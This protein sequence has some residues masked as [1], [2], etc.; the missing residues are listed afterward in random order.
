MKVVAILLLGTLLLN[1]CGN[2]T[3]P[4]QEAAGGIWEA[5]L[6]G[7][8]G[9]ESGFSFITQFTVNGDASLSVSSFQ[10]LTD[11]A[12]GC[13][14]VAGETPTGSMP[15]IVNTSTD[16][17]TGTLTFEV[18][19]G[20]STPSTLTLSGT[21]TGTENGVNGTTLSGT[22]ITGTWTLTGCSSSSTTNGSFTMTQS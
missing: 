8:T 1:G 3:T 6:L 4:V 10:F 5:Q 17:V 21:V 9:G 18:Q 14:G 12:A 22:S 16:A 19:S 13:F 15:L 20:G 2:N 7:G 11:N